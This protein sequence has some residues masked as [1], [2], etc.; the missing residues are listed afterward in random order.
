MKRFWLLALLMAG[1]L[2]VALSSSAFAKG[3]VTSDDS[4]DA[5]EDVNSALGSLSGRVGDV[6]K[7][8]ALEIEIHGFAETD[9]IGDDTQSFLETVGNGAVKRAGQYV[10]D[11]GWTQFSLRNSRLSFLAKAADIDGWKTKGYIEAD[12]LGYD[13]GPGYGAGLSAAAAATLTG[14]GQVASANNEYKFYTQPTFRLRHAYLDAQKDG[15]E[16]MAGQWWTLYGWNMDYV[17]ATVSLQP[18]MGTLYERTPQLRVMK[19]LGLSSGPQVQL[20]VDA[21]KS[22]QLISEMPDLNWGVRFIMNDWKGR[23]AYATG[24]A[25]LRPLSLGFSQT[26]RNY[27]WANNVVNGVVDSGDFNYSNE[28]GSALAVDAFIPIKP[29]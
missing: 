2:M 5:M 10:G 26:N 13:P 19:T 4:S 8:Q 3:D 21:E 28:W 14:T 11:N 9:A 17:L 22:Q 7:K 1:S 12:F 27:V 25:G 6:E 18:V 29:L 15:W 24:A 20:A 23:F 16:F